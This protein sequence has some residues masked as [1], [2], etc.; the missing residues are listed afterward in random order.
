MYLSF[1]FEIACAY[2]SDSVMDGKSHEVSFIAVT[3]PQ[4]LSLCQRHIQFLEV[5]K[6]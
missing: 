2:E 5:S 6:E 3:S 4:N 1:V